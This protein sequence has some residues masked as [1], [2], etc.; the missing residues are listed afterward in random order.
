MPRLD[1]KKDANH[2][3]IKEVN[4]VLNLANIAKLVKAIITEE[5]R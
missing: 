2:D 5:G 1:A 4:A 3:D